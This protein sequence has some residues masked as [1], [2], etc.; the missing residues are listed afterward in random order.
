MIALLL[1]KHLL[2]VMKCDRLKTLNLETIKLINLYAHEEN[3]DD[4]LI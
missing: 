1:F 3:C 4:K 2:E